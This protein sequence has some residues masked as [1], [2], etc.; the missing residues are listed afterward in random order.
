MG[1]MNKEA[2]TKLI[3]DDIAEMEKWMPKYSLA[4]RHAIEVL[5]HS[6]NVL[7]ESDEISYELDK[8]DINRFC[9]SCKKQV[10]RM[11]YVCICGYQF[12]TE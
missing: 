2:Y 7:Y 12:M 6:I 5:R 10:S 3:D 1:T 11:Q 4:K 8:V 9:P